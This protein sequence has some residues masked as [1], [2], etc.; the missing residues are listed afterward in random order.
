MVGGMVDGSVGKVI[1]ARV[2]RVQI[3]STHIKARLVA[4][5]MGRYRREDPGGVM[6]NHSNRDVSY[7]IS[8]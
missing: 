1:S 7:R 4:A 8:E 5:T 2:N 6:T 3:P